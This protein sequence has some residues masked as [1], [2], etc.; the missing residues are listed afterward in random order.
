MSAPAAASPA[1]PEA[2]RGAPGAQSQGPA[3]G[4]RSRAAGMHLE[5]RLS[6]QRAGGP[7]LGGG[8]GGG[9]DGAD[10]SHHGQ[11][12]HSPAPG[13]GP[14]VAVVSPG[15]GRP[16]E[17]ASG[18]GRGAASPGPGARAAGHRGGGVGRGC[19]RR[20]PL[21]ACPDG[22]PG[23]PRVFSALSPAPYPWRCRPSP[24]ASD[25]G[26]LGR[27]A[28]VERK[29]TDFWEMSV[30][31]RDPP[32][33]P[34]ALLTSLPSVGAPPSSPRPPGVGAAAKCP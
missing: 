28:A 27:S 20:R 15:A 21:T 8:G 30:V 19:L 2:G 10:T 18:E 32:L 24:G 12:R 7:S 14:R 31:P 1:G 6:L 4:G 17:R 9:S 23:R 25:L 29:G 11:L 5:R 34:L 26:S 16:A 3:G 13:M 33:G 22:R